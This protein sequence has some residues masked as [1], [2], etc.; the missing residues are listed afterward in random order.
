[1]WMY[2]SI[3]ELMVLV[4]RKIPLLGYSL[5]NP[6]SLGELETFLNEKRSSRN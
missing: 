3:I 5:G 6:C 2:D 1:M 4:Q